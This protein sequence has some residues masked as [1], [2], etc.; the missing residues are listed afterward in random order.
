MT[1][2]LE[3]HGDLLESKA[4]ALV[5]PVN[6]VGAM[7]KGLALTFKEKHPDFYYRYKQQCRY[8]KFHENTLMVFQ[9]SKAPYRIVALPTKVHWGDPSPPELVEASIKRLAWLGEQKILTSV[10][11]PA[12]GCGE[13]QLEYAQVR[14]WIYQHLDPNP[15]DV[16]IWL[17]P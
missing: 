5:C 9:P 15:M 1:V 6:A 7:G 16:E 10:A 8:R 2:V 17:Q 4:S 3:Q 14:E 13:G 12:L 11:L